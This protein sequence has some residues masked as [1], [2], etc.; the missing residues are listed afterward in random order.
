MLELVHSSGE[1]KGAFIGRLRIK[2]W[3]VRAL[4]PFGAFIGA[5]RIAM[6]G[7][8]T[9]AVFIPLI[10]G[11]AFL[12][13]L[14]AEQCALY[15]WAN[16]V[17]SKMTKPENSFWL[18]WSDVKHFEVEASGVLVAIVACQG[19]GARRLL[20]STKAW[21]F[22]AKAVRH[23]CDELNRRAELHPTG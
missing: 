15:C 1:N 16:G 18:A 23:M 9:A 3:P 21:S 2:P 5:G 11:I 20:P 14:A 10:L 19:N 4:I 17:E 13:V 8:V 6:D 12:W 7:G 22:Q